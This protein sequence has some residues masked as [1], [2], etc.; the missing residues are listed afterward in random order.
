MDRPWLALLGSPFAAALVSLPLLDLEGEVEGAYGEVDGLRVDSPNLHEQVEQEPALGAHQASE[1]LR[2]P[3][4]PLHG[5][6]PRI[7]LVRRLR[8]GAPLVVVRQQPQHLCEVLACL[9]L[10]LVPA[11]VEEAG[12]GTD[13]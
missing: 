12:E 11:G 4:Q 3:G 1:Q 7:V 10:V 5:R 9:G 2:D 13:P 8:Q 6:H